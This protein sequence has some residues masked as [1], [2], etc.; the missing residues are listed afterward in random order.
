MSTPDREPS[1]EILITPKSGHLLPFLKELYLFRELLLFLVW[2]DIKVQF[3]QTTLGLGWLV[4]RPLL[5]V[6]VLTL[7][8]G[9]IARIPSDGVPYLLFALAGIMPWSYFSGSVNKCAMS[10]VGNAGLV[11]KIYFPRIYIPFSMV[12][13]GMIEFVVT[14][15][16]F[17]LAS[18]FFYGR[19]PPADFWLLIVPLLLLLITTVGVSLWLASLAVDFRDVRHASQY[20]IQ[21]L[22]FAAPVIWPLS[23]LP[24]RFGAVGEHFLDWYALYPMVGVVEGFRHVLLGTGEMPWSY[25]G[26]GYITAVLLLVSGVLH[27]RRR[28]RLLADFV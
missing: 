1:T 27:F 17:M 12:L 24:Q 26:T 28:E 2:K 25:I 18:V 23:L 14:F 22:M 15:C 11:T 7:V 19:L 13:S 9:K 10:L 16:L 8:F 3:A 6:A 5:N 21:M 4:L 20:L